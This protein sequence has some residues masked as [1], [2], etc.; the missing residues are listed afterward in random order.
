MVIVDVL[1][2]VFWVAVLAKATHWVIDNS[3]K[4]SEFFG[5]GTMSIGFVLVS[6]ATSLPE[7]S[8][9][10]LSSSAGGGAI[11]V[12][13]VFGSN[14]ADILIVLGIPAVI[15]GI[16]IGKRELPGI[17]AI[18]A[19]TSA[20]TIAIMLTGSIGLYEG[21]FLLLVWA[22]YIYYLFSRKESLGLK[23]TVTKKDALTS[24]IL[25]SIGVLAVLVSSEFVVESALRIA[26]EADIAKSF[27]GATIIAIGTSLP[28]LAVD[29][30][31]ISK[32]QYGLALGDAIGSSLTNVTLVLGVTAVIHEVKLAMNVF[33][34]VLAFAL[35]ANAMML[36][37]VS[38][39]K[40]LG[41]R[42][43]AAMLTVYALFI[44]ILSA[45]QMQAMQ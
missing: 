18:L 30:R 33:F 22:G 39:K 16:K 23:N 27:I 7:I 32:K 10:V 26:Q 42:E 35:V 21:I 12:G 17:A 25:F 19:I 4:L 15:Y 11:S 5:I 8:V 24:F 29:L 36:Y 34:V 41:R 28:E 13:N 31:A 44:I 20:I 2:I 43:G 1:L 6:T 37:Y 38:R 9:A 40:T 45:T 14:I 3:I